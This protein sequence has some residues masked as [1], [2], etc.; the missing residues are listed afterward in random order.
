MQLERVHGA[1]W[2]RAGHGARLSAFKS[3]YTV[4]F[5]HKLHAEALSRMDHLLSLASVSSSVDACVLD[6]RI[7]KVSRIL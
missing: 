5:P 4:Y 7:C 1:L 2:L 6:K 3:C